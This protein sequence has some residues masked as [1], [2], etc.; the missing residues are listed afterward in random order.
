[1]HVPPS[2]SSS[3]SYDKGTE[4]ETLNDQKAALEARVTAIDGQKSILEGFSDSVKAGRIKDLTNEKLEEFMDVFSTRELKMYEDKVRLRKEIEVIDTRIEDIHEKISSEGEK[5]ANGVTVILLAE[6]TGPV[7]L[8]LFYGKQ[9]VAV[10]SM[11]AHA[12][13][14]V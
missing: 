3:I 14:S 8:I 2:Y 4:L 9:S 10:R 12:S 5:R 7:D 6:E 11:P 1:V 13:F